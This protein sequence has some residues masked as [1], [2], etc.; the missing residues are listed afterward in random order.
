MKFSLS[1]PSFESVRA[2]G[3]DIQKYTIPTLRRVRDFLMVNLLDGVFYPRKSVVISIERRAV[4]IAVANLFLSKIRVVSCRNYSFDDGRFPLPE[5]FASTISLAMDEAKVRKMPI[6]ISL[7]KEWVVVRK[8]ELPAA[9]KDNL[10]DVIRYELDRF[11]PFSHDEALYDFSIFG[12]KDEKL[13]I[14]LSVAR[15]GQFAPYVASLSEKGI[16][17]KRITAETVCLAALCR[18]MTDGAD[19]VCLSI[20]KDE[21]TGCGSVRGVVVSPFTGDLVRENGESNDTLFTGEITPLIETMAAYG[22]EPR[23]TVVG[24]DTMETGLD[25]QVPVPAVRVTSDAIRDRLNAP[26]QDLP[27]TTAGAVVE[28]LWD[29]AV[30]INLLS[31]GGMAKKK[32]PLLVTVFLVF[33]ILGFLVPYAMLPLEVEKRRLT[34]IERQ[35][36][37]RKDEVKKVDALKKEIEGVEAEI[38]EIRDFKETRPMVLSVMKELTLILPKTAW[39]TRVRI[40]EEKIEVEGYAQ[41]ATEILPKL[42]QSKLFRK[43]EFSSPTIRDTRMNA[44]RFVIKMELEGYEKKD[45]EKKEAPSKTE[46]AKKEGAAQSPAKTE[47]GKKDAGAP[48]SAKTEPAKKEPAVP[49]PSKTEPA[50]K[51]VEK[52]LPE[53]KI[54]EKRER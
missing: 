13:L 27:V 34:E 38:K 42:E 43:A 1:L 33:V 18:Y 32:I 30:T 11:T 5:N 21:F 12:E 44:D 40:A 17:V 25:E 47:P 53:K 28:D 8:A 51:D 54:P 3:S 48:V 26:G 41:S 23:L 14:S 22:I 15:E 7:P 35:V 20:M 50:K 2:F 29:K 52:R 31:K 39:T 49:P 19:T 10:A 36:S 9:V 6:V 37:V 24:D 4:N 46:P 45:G 16:K